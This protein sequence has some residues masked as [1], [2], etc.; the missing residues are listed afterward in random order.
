[1]SPT[2]DSPVKR[3][4]FVSGV[5]V[6]VGGIEKS[7]MDI[8]RGLDRNELLIDFV[9]RKPQVGCYH[10]EIESYG[11]KIFNLF[12]RT[13]HKGIKKWNVSSDVY[14][15]FEFYKIL[16]NEGPYAAVHIAYPN[17]DGYM[18]A[19]AKLAGVPVR[20]IH[21]HNTGFDDR[22]QPNLIRRMI[23]KT[24]LAIGRSLATHIWGCSKAACEYMF[25]SD[26]MKDR[27]AEVVRNPIDIKKFKDLN[28]DKQAARIQLNLPTDKFVLLNVSRFAV[29]KNHKFLIDV[30]GEIVKRRSDVHLM[31]IGTGPLEN[32]LKDYI[33]KSNLCEFVSIYDKNTSVPV[34]LSAA[35]YFIL[36]SI[37]EGFGNTLIEAQAADVPCIAST[38][39]QPEP[40]L[41]MV[42]YLPLNKGPESW[43]DFIISQLG[44]RDRRKVNLNELFKYDLKTVS[45]H[46]QNTY[47]K[48]TKFSEN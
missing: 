16:K 4:L 46:M 26:I 21:S 9:V 15:L 11:G 45:R 42:D 5:P 29:Q 38:A 31:L 3:V 2:P 32:E 30:L 35:D 48:G 44:Q 27:R 40:N 25:G 17:L 37:Y 24:A 20:I 12:N 18:I 33:R 1:M 36:P 14:S 23:R 22:N 19:A 7:I 13:K 39:C 41:G 34:A 28:V 47:L 10:E 43:G 6:D 8:Y